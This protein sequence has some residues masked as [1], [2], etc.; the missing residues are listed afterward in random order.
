MVIVVKK[1]ICDIV[2]IILSILTLI[3]FETY[4]YKAIDLIGIN[5]FSYSTIIQTIINVI[6]KLIICFIIYIIF[7]KDFR[8]RTNR[9]N[10]LK[11]LLYLIVGVL[12]VSIIMYLF[13]YVIAFLGDVFDINILVK[14]FYNIFNKTLNFDLVVRILID[15]VIKPYLYCS[16]ILL[17]VD[18]L[19]NRN[20]TCIILSGLLALIINAFS[21]NGTLGFVIINSL[22]MFLLFAILAY[23]YRKRNSISFIIIL[24]SFYLLSNVIIINYLR[25]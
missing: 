13:D 3:Y 19:C 11:N 22:S 17:S 5:I 18:K 24:Y 20:N 16:V 25:W 4:F 2:G 23:L 12:V 8:K 7:K 14:D 15:Y 10:L 1:K 21:L 6:I 9:E